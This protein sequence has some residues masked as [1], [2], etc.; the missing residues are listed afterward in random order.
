MN[1]G[2]EGTPNK[3]KRPRIKSFENAT[4]DSP[5]LQ[6]TT[7]KNTSEIE[8]KGESKQMTSS[9]QENDCPPIS[10][11]FRREPQSTDRQILNELK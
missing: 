5:E 3:N 1:Q 8:N 2:A 4:D 6:S 7:P 10:L 9:T 11:K